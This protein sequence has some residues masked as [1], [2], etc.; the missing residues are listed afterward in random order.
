MASP[1]AS[2][3]DSR[4]AGSV[5]SFSRSLPP[6]ASRPAKVDPSTSG[7]A[8]SGPIQDS[9]DVRILAHA[10]SKCIHIRVPMT[11]LS[12]LAQSVPCPLTWSTHADAGA[13]TRAARAGGSSRSGKSG[14]TWGCSTA[15]GIRSC[16][17]PCSHARVFTPQVYARRAPSASPGPCGTTCARG[18]ASN[19]KDRDCSGRCGPR[20]LPRAC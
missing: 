17:H 13:R 5:N 1:V 6:I 12:C 19:T 11:P 18:T 10:N 9:P 4:P 14:T 8:S 7:T 16:S 2:V 3:L 15:R 20:L